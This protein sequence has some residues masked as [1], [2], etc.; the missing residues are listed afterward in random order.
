LRNVATRHVFFHNG[1]YHTLEQVL[2]FYDDRDTAPQKIYPRNAHGVLQTFN[3]LPAR[4]RPNIDTID[5]PF[6]RRAG[7]TP[8]LDTAEEHDIIAFLDTLTD[9][10]SR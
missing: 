8:V 7:Q 4:Y 1:V 2:D 3:D 5:P 10:Y 6:D 9:G